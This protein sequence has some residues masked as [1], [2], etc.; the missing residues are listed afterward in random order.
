MILLEMIVTLLKALLWLLGAVLALILFAS[1]TP[2][3]F[4]GEVEDLQVAEDTGFGWQQSS[5]RLRVAWLL[6]LAVLEGGRKAGEPFGLRLRLFGLPVRLNIGT[7]K[8]AEG[9]VNKAASGEI[10]RASRRSRKRNRRR[11]SLH[12]AP[13]LLSELSWL[14]VRVRRTMWIEAEGDVIY[15]FS[16][17]SL[18]GLCEGLRYQLGLVRRLRL[19]PDYTEGRLEPTIGLKTY[20]ILMGVVLLRWAFRKRVRRLWWP[21]RRQAAMNAQ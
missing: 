13:G 7:G 12:D 3:R 21:Q 10:E 8:K 17:P 6:G 5:Y 15:G 2:L 19:T 14:I 9:G 1:C 20:P 11:L 4:T 18:T 16:D